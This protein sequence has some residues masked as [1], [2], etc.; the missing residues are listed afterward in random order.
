MPAYELEGVAD[1][2]Y[3]SPGRAGRVVVVPFHFFKPPEISLFPFTARTVQG[4]ARAAAGDIDIVRKIGD[5]FAEPHLEFIDF[6]GQV[7]SETEFPQELTDATHT[8]VGL[9]F[10]E[11]ENSHPDDLRSVHDAKLRHF[12][13]TRRALV[14]SSIR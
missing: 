3:L 12:G 11:V 4:A 2:E 5:F 14:T 1:K 7:M 8:L 10:I 13:E 9:S 6:K